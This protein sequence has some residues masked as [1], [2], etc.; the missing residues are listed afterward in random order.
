[1]FCVSIWMSC[2]IWNAGSSDTPMIGCRGLVFEATDL[3]VT[4]ISF[5]PR[6]NPILT[7]SPILCLP[8]SWTAVA[9]FVTR[10]P[11]IETIRS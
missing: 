9:G 2:G 8:R 4:D 1:M 6:M 10:V 3:S 7:A 11:S 5:F